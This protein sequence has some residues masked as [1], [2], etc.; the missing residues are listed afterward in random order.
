MIP[1]REDPNPEQNF[2]MVGRLSE[3]I[4]RQFNSV[5]TEDG[6]VTRLA[7]E[8][9]PSK[10]GIKI[11]VNYKSDVLGIWQFQ[12]KADEDIFSS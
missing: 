9:D 12:I 1:T 10:F 7:P 4:C 2:I 6:K 8:K 5:T 3:M 11:P